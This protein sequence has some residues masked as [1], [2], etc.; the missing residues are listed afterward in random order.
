MRIRPV[1]AATVGVLA[2]LALAGCPSGSG[3]SS[4]SPS[5]SSPSASTSATGASPRPSIIRDQYTSQFAAGVLKQ[6][7]EA[8][9]AKN[10]EAICELNASTAPT[11]PKR[12]SQADCVRAVKARIS[13]EDWMNVQLDCWASAKDLAACGGMTPD[14]A[15]ARTNEL[16]NFV[17]DSNT[18]GFIFSSGVPEGCDPKNTTGCWFVVAYGSDGLVSIAPHWGERVY[19]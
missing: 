10:P 15:H 3:Q 12:I 4:P 5:S 9:V 7:L 2:A 19:R 14:P 11:N 13:G 6:Y 16:N 8:L 17:F 18:E 1:L